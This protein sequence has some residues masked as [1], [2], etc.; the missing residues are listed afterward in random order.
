MRAHRPQLAASRMP[1]DPRRYFLSYDSIEEIGKL[2]H[3]GHVNDS[4]L[5]EYGATA[6]ALGRAAIVNPDWPQRIEGPA[7]QPRRPPSRAPSFTSAASPRPSPGTC[8][9]GK[10]SSP[11]DRK[12]GE[13][14]W[15]VQGRWWLRHHG[16]TGR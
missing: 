14:S 4:I 3:L 1:D 9:D 13:S 8:A 15:L 5:S 11:T 6:V 10:A 2:P 7:W 16:M 12:A